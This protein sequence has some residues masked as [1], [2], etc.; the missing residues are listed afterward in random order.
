MLNSRIEDS[1]P[2]NNISPAEIARIKQEIERM[3]TSEWQYKAG[4]HCGHFASRIG[5]RDD[6]K[7]N[8]SDVNGQWKQ[9]YIDAWNLQR[10]R[11]AI[12]L[13]RVT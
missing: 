2:D 6:A 10:S 1:L 12:A 5:V 3:D 8:R 13:R 7:L 4:W 9:G 11:I